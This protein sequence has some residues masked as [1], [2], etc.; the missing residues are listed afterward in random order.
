MIRSTFQFNQMSLQ[1]LVAFLSEI[2]GLAIDLCLHQQSIDTTAPVGRAM[3]Q[4]M[5]VFAE[6]ERSMI[7]ERVR[8]GL[9]R[10]PRSR[11]P[12]RQS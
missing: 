5:T 12:Y 2:H 8:A 4:M 11:R 10:A 9:A 6:F 3:F 1:D 7:Q